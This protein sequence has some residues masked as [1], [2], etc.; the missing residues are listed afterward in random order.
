MK[1]VLNTSDIAALKITKDWEMKKLQ[2][3]SGRKKSCWIHVSVGCW[4][5]ISTPGRPYLIKAVK[6]FN[7]T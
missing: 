3:C 5:E 6:E 1:E 2:T 4:T 7:S